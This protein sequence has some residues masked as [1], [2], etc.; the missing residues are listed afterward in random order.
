MQVVSADA[1]PL[2]PGYSRNWTVRFAPN[3]TGTLQGTLWLQTRTGQTAQVPLL[4]TAVH[5][6][7]SL[8]SA[9]T[10][11]PLPTKRLMPFC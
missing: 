4:G 11:V 10:A 5:P 6:K 3:E 8:P 1:S 9:G 7:I 2:A